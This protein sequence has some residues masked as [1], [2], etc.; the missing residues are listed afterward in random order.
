MTV[1]DSFEA[2]AFD[3]RLG[4]G[5]CAQEGLGR[6]GPVGFLDYPMVDV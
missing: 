2:A 5:D 1:H 3:L 4:L 6:A